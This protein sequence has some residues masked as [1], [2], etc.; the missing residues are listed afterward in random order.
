VHSTLLGVVFY[1]DF[2]IFIFLFLFPEIANF[3]PLC[4]FLFFVGT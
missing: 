3:F 4:I 1:L 2:G